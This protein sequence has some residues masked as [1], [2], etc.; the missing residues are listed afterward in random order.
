MV[1]AVLTQNTNW[2]NVE[3]AIGN[4]KRK[5]LLSVERLHGLSLSDLAEEIRPAGY[6][7]VKA[8]RLKNLIRFVVEDHQ[9]DLSLLFGQALQPLR[10]GLLSVT[11]VGPETADSIIL[12]GAP[13]PRICYRCLHLPHLQSTRT[14]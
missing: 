9:G 4:L 10:Q 14:G 2:K 7:N 5:D 13:S 1:G 12:Y 8:K 3:K 6:F 11:G